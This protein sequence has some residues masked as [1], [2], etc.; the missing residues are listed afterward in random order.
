MLAAEHGHTETVQALIAADADIK[1]TCQ[2]VSIAIHTCTV[3]IK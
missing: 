1:V 2:R 3:I